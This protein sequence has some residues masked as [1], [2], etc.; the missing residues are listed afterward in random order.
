MYGVERSLRT[1]APLVALLWLVALPASAVGGYDI[2]HIVERT[3][4]PGGPLIVTEEYKGSGLRDQVMTEPGE[5]IACP[6]AGLDDPFQIGAGPER[7]G[8]EPYLCTYF[9]LLNG[10]GADVCVGADGSGGERSLMGPMMAIRADGSGRLA[11]AGIVSRDVATVRVTPAPALVREPTV[12]QIER[13][14][15]ARLGAAGPFGY[16]SLTLDSRAV[17]ADETRVLGR[18]S[19]GRRIAGSAVPPSTRLLSAVDRVPYSSS[20]K[21]LC[22]SQAASEPAAPAWFMGMAAAL[23]SLLV[24]LT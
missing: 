24:A 15:A 21:G 11:L 17:C 23:R 19:S 6:P 16:F 18:D 3:C 1:V 22:E 7:I 12:V 14:R 2:A 4:E 5:V 13:Q 20:L 10:D 8:G 9:S